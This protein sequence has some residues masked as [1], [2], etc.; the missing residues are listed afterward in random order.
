MTTTATA[1]SRPNTR[2]RAAAAAAAAS[3]AAAAHDDPRSG[4]PTTSSAAP[5]PAAAGAP[6]TTAMMI[7]QRHPPT[8]PATAT[9]RTAA[10][11]LRS[12]TPPS[13]HAS[14][15]AASRAPPSHSLTPPRTTKGPAARPIPPS[16]PLPSTS[17]LDHD[18]VRATAHALYHAK[19]VVVVAGAGISVSAGIPDFRSENGLYALV[20]SAHAKDVV[21]GQDLF[22]AALFRAEATTRLF[23]Q[24]MAGLRDATRAANPTLTHRFL[25]SLDE[26]GSLL[27]VYTQNIDG[28]E[29][30]AG[31][32]NT[33]VTD[34]HDSET[35]SLLDVTS[36]SDS[37]SESE[38]PLPVKPLALRVHG[39]ASIANRTP[40]VVELH[41]SLDTVR[42]T[43][44]A[45]QFPFT[46]RFAATYAD[47][48]AP[49]CPSCLRDAR[50]RETAG[51]RV[52]GTGALRPNVV[53]YNETHPAGDEIADAV[54]H[55][56][57]KRPDVLV[58]MGTSLKVHG[59]KR[60]VRDFA[61]VIHDDG[62]EDLDVERLSLGPAPPARQTRKNKKHGLVILVNR[63]PLPAKEWGDVF[64]VVLTGD[65]DDVVHQWVLEWQRLDDEAAERRHKRELAA[66]R[67]AERER[68]QTKLQFP[69]VKPTEVVGK[70]DVGDARLMVGAEHSVPAGFQRTM[71][72]F[73]IEPTE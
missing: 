26:R 69:V 53:L 29:S 63:T 2:A 22:D 44:C 8:R 24:F 7:R 25:R 48:A 33:G 31:I 72:L 19:R 49:A 71:R 27:R 11:S 43:R 9:A 65:A 47:G 41:G 4:R 6:L 54:S 62:S 35:D 58:V 56:L 42:C 52:R 68:G 38:R 28:L 50:E 5:K 51:K 20:K 21:K 67:R 66:A 32:G 1:S 45:D 39:T 34:D 23:Y 64:D 16:A 55:D 18:H 13:A 59:I 70:V 17:K 36:L 10:A 60:L 40:R 61:A 3:A 15:G 30:R 12:S 37:E 57:R 73:S 14:A 46:S